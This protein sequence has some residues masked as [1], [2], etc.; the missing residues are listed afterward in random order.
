MRIFIRNLAVLIGLVLPGA[1]LLTGA[2][3]QNPGDVSWPAWERLQAFVYFWILTIP[4][5]TCGTAI[6]HGVMVVG[7][8]IRHRFS[9]RALAV[10]TSPLV[11]TW[12]FLPTSWPME[13]S[14]R[15]Q[16]QLLLPFVFVV[17]VYAAL[18]LPIPRLR[19]ESP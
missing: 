17:G 5:V 9:D 15:E 6:H 8:N 12:W 2:L 4:L 11:L 16:P 18:V 7:A 1:I 19:Q 14:L 3:L 13:P 10:G